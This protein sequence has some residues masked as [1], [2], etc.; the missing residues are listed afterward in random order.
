M[1]QHWN[2]LEHLV[3]TLPIAYEDAEKLKRLG[4]TY[5]QI[6]QFAK[7]GL[8]VDDSIHWHECVKTLIDGT[9]NEFLK[10]PTKWLRVRRRR[11]PIRSN[12]ELRS[13]S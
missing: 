1:K 13:I 11:R 12:N 9:T 3:I 4:F 8:D 7:A 6:R 10:E 5:D 2:W